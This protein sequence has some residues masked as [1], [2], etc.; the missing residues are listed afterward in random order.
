MVKLDLASLASVRQCAE[1]LL[2]AAAEFDVILGNAGL[3]IGPKILTEDG[4]EA[5]FG[6]NFL[7]H[8]LLI[9]LVA[10]L[11]KPSGRIALVSSA[12][13]RGAD[14]NLDDVNFERSPYDPLKAYRRSKTATVLFAVEFDRRYRTRGV[15]ATAVHPGAVLTD[16]TRNLLYVAS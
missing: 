6:T 7:G 11:I 1:D 10:K 13:H 16:T 4:V 9:N 12:G 15:R 14:I 8:F 5:Q 3:M 2:N